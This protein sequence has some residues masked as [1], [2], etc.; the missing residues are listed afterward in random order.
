MRL[1][2][3]IIVLEHGEVAETGTYDQLISS[4]GA[5]AGLVQQAPPPG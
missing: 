3:R 5:L 1:A 2:D 4:D